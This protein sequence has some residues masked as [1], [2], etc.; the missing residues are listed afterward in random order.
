MGDELARILKFV[1]QSTH[2]HF[3]L[4]SRVEGRQT[5]DHFIKYGSQGIVVNPITV[6]VSVEHFWAHILSRST[7]CLIEVAW[8]LHFRKTKIRQ[9]DMSVDVNEN[10]FRF[11]VTI[12]DV[13]IMDVLQSE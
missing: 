6:A 4:V 9:L 8:F 3:I 2:E 5:C 10:I 13:L 11:Q 12:E 7:V 1:V